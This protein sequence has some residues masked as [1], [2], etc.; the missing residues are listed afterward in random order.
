MNHEN[1]QPK[2]PQL[3]HIGTF[4]LSNLSI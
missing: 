4:R 3:K 1:Q 2:K